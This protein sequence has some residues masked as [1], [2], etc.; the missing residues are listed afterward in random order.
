MPWFFRRPLHRVS[1]L[2]GGCDLLPC[3]IAVQRQQQCECNKT[4]KLR[5]VLHDLTS[6]RLE[7]GGVWV[8]M[9][10]PSHKRICDSSPSKPKLLDQ[11]RVSCAC[12]ITAFVP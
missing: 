7:F 5:R 12:G 6:I 2:F 8:R 4:A 11:V 1:F 3:C 10:G 9:G